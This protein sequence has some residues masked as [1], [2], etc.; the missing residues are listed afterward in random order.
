MNIALFHVTLPVP[1]RKPGGVS[2]A[3]DRLATAL[4]AHPSDAVTVFSLTPGPAAPAYR[5]V[6]LFPDKPWLQTP[7]TS[8]VALPL[9]LNSVSFADFDVLHLHGD[10]WFFVR[11]ALPTVRTLH[12]SALHE[13]RFATSNKRRLSQRLLYPLEQ[14]SARLATVTAAVGPETARVYHTP[15]VVGN[16]VDLDH[17]CPGPKSA[18]PSI[19]FVGTWAGRKRGEMLYDTFTN[20]IAPR[21][22]TARLYMVSDACPPH[23]QVVHV[24]RPSDEALADLY[25]QAWVFAYPSV[26]E[27]FGI[28]YLEAMASGTPVLCSPNEGAEYVLDGGRYGWIRSDAAFSS[29]LNDLLVDAS[30][31]TAL[32]TEGRKR[33][34]DFTWT[35]VARHHRQ[36]YETAI[37]RFSGRPCSSPRSASASGD[38]TLAPKKLSSAAPNS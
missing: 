18:H 17:F 9:L 7:P 8:H 34:R 3:V 14:L 38:T 2:V 19:L 32:A 16:G 4:S 22:P 6:Q 24:Q 31:R 28:P 25:R 1:N 13:A 20:E 30:A 21:H 35:N 5:H 23:D 36:L 11:R 15:H 26:Y 10:D 12:G 29:A 33:A 37:D 27:G